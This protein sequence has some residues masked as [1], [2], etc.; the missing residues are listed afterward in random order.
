MKRRNENEKVPVPSSTA[1]GKFPTTLE[2]AIPLPFDRLLT[3]VQVA[4][5][6]GVRP[7]RVY[8]LDIPGVRL[9][10]RC[11]RWRLSDVDRWIDRH[12]SEAA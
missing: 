10:T 1:I 2:T 5:P 8:E 4:E 12:R 3:A 9:S 6:L 7:K 11:I